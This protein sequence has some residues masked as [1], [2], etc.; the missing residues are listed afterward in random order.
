MGG[1]GA[2]QVRK[3]APGAGCGRRRGVE[4][5]QGDLKKKKKNWFL[6]NYLITFLELYLSEKDSNG[7]MRERE[8]ERRRIGSGYRPRFGCR[9]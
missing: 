4:I 6:K 3:R 2:A 8:R 7:K 5:G 9:C 1:A